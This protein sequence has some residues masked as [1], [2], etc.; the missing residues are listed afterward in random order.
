MADPF[1]RLSQALMQGV[2]D[3]PLGMPYAL[4]NAPFEKPADS[5]PWGKVF[6]LFNDPRVATLGADGQDGHDGILQIDLNYPLLTGD[7]AATAKADELSNFF[8]AGK[9]LAIGGV[10]QLIITSC[11]RSHGR[12]VDGWYRVS[13]SVAWDA[14]IPRAT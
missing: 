14:R 2:V 8:I 4:P 7:A 6:I 3:S 11:G 9:R 13:V 12:E 10:S 1:S 5:A